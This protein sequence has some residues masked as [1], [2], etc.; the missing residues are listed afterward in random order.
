MTTE[1]GPYR[2]VAPAASSEGT[3][4][5]MASSFAKA[6]PTDAAARAAMVTQFV[7]ASD[8]Y[9][10]NLLRRDFRLS[11]EAA[12]AITSSMFAKLLKQERSRTL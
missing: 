1:A 8:V 6:L 9:T 10:R 4:E 12:L 2:H 3:P 5:W 7:I 11:V